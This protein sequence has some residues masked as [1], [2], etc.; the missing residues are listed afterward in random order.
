MHKK[1]VLIFVILALGL[2]GAAPSSTRLTRLTIVNKSG[3]A[4]EISLTGNETKQF[5]YL[6]VP[7]GDRIA[8]AEREF[9]VIP[10]TYAS[11]VHYVELWDPVYGYQ[12]KS[13]G[14]TLEL[15]H[16]VRATVFDCEHNPPNGGEPPAIVKYGGGGRK[17]A[18]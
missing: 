9:T 15:K 2:I 6:H 3:R 16:N 5:Y 17:M 4:V 1:T 10:D 8:P 14:L 11:T 13:E 7:E 12:C 18:R